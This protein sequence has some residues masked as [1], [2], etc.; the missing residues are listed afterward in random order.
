[1]TYD[2]HNDILRVDP[3]SLLEK[4][5]VEYFLDN[6]DKISLAS[7]ENMVKGVKPP[8]LEI[9]KDV[10]MYLNEATRAIGNAEDELESIR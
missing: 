10:I 6:F 5:K 1:M 3:D 9:V 2:E 8:D 4:M 7:L